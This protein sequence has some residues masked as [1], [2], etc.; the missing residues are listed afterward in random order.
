MENVNYLTTLSLRPPGASDT[1]CCLPINQSED[2]AWTDHTPWDPLPHLL[3]FIYL[4]LKFLFLLYFTLQYCIRFAIHWHESSMGVPHLLLKML[5]KNLQGA[6]GALEHELQL[7]LPSPAVNL[8]L[9]CTL[10][11]RCAWP[12]CV[13]GTWTCTNR[14]SWVRGCLYHVVTL[15]PLAGYLPFLGFGLLLW[16]M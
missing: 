12:H 9:F 1:I 13:S 11:S 10:M 14:T 16:K 2:C 7:S 15:W 5:C 6:L 8:S 3:L 4:F